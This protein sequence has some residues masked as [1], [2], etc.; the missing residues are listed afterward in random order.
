[1]TN[2][3]NKIRNLLKAQAALAHLHHSHGDERG[4][5]LAARYE[6][7][8]CNLAVAYGIADQPAWRREI[9]ETK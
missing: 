7:E 1:M 2:V 4:L 9:M 8:A 6:R 5:E 3:K